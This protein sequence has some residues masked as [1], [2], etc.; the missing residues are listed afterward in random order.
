MKKPLQLEGMVDPEAAPVDT[1]I[2]QRGARKPKPERRSEQMTFRLLPSLRAKVD[3][4]AESEDIAIA[5]VMERA[6]KAYFRKA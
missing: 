6:L 1:G 5:E 4:E 2:P 3:A